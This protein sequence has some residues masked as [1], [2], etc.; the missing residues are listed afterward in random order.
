MH[1]NICAAE[2]SA[3]LLKVE[4]EQVNDKAWAEAVKWADAERK[5]AIAERDQAEANERA[6]R[7]EAEMH[8]LWQKLHG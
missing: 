4:L 8:K 1:A 3:Q 2:E 7:L 6:S 5:Q